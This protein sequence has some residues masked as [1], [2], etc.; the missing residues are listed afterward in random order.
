MVKGLKKWLRILVAI[1]LSIGLIVVA[2]AMTN[3]YLGKKYEARVN[4]IRQEFHQNKALYDDCIALAQRIN[5]D[6]DFSIYY[7]VD[8]HRTV[9]K[10]DKFPV[11]V[12][13]QLLDELNVKFEAMKYF[14]NGLDVWVDRK[15]MRF[16]EIHLDALCS[17]R[18]IDLAY[19]ES[20]PS[21]F[22]GEQLSKH[23]FLQQWYME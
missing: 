16:N 8:L 21:K 23:W 7:D 4:A 2:V 14:R 22:Y 19:Y 1:C 13:S 5:T 12:D 17:Y 18:E 15:S 10:C 20:P 11:D 6:Q 9:V 3:L